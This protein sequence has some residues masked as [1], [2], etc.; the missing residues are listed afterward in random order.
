M[1]AG[2]IG[3]G[4]HGR[5]VQQRCR[6]EPRREE[7]RQ[8]RSQA[9]A[10]LPRRIEQTGRI[11]SGR[12]P[13]FADPASGEWTWSDDGAWSSG[14][15][16]GMLWLADAATGQARFAALAAE[17]AHRLQGLRRHPH[18]RGPAGDGGAAE[19]MP[20]RRARRR[21]SDPEAQPPQKY[22]KLS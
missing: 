13:V 1:I 14:F 12:F 10:G 7:T 17:S 3:G 19:L 22:A 16:P 9:L 8:V 6:H 15:W 2:A 5:P 4:Q 21:P 11:A 20:P 18:G